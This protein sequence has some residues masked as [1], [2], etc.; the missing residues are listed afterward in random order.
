M[1]AITIIAGVA[2]L[3]LG[4]AGNAAAGGAELYVAK[5]CA[6]CHGADAN[7][8]IMPVY[9]KLAGQSAAYALNQ[10]NDIKSG[11]R[12]NGQSIA[13]KGLVATVPDAELKEIAD[14][15]ATQ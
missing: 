10:I 12:A 9:P 14:W 15:L 2:L 8:P 4:L 3:S 6:A 1:K 13:M 7:T 5:G 11:A